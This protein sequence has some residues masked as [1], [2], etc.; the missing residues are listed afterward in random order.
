M[1]LRPVNY[2]HAVPSSPIHAIVSA[3]SDRNSCGANGLFVAAGAIPRTPL[4]QKQ[5]GV[6]TNSEKWDIGNRKSCDS[7][8]LRRFA[9]ELPHF[10]HP[11]FVIASAASP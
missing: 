2:V 6:T 4:K 8:A 10:A 5:I 9:F 7:R 1:V 11:D 3:D